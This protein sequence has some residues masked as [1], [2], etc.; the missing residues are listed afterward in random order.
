MFNIRVVCEIISVETNS[1][2]KIFERSIKIRY[3]SGEP[4]DSEFN[5][6]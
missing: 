4:G 6:E 1:I 3:L 2:K 5:W